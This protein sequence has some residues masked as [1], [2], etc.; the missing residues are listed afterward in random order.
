MSVHAMHAPPHTRSPQG[1][2]ESLPRKVEEFQ[3]LLPDSATEVITK[4][5]KKHVSFKLI[6]HFARKKS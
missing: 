4:T 6:K 5:Q 1:M 3:V 2:I